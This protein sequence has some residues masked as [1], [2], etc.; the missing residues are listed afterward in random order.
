MDGI[1]SGFTSNGRGTAIL[2]NSSRFEYKKLKLIKDNENGNFITIEIET[3]NISVLINIYGPNNDDPGF[4]RKICADLEKFDTQ[5]Y[6]FFCADWNLIL[7]CSLDVYNYKHINNP[8]ARNYVL[9]MCN[10]L[11]LVDVWRVY[12]ENERKYTWSRRN[13][14]PLMS[15]LDFFLILDDILNFVSDTNI[16]PGYRTD[17]SAITLNL[18]FSP[19]SRGKGYWKFNNSLLHDKN[20]VKLIKESIEEIKEQYAVSPYTRD[21]IKKCPPEELQLQINDQ[22][23][24]EMIL[25]HLRGKLIPYASHK[26]KISREK[27]KKIEEEIMLLEDNKINNPLDFNI[28]DQL[29][30]KQKELEDSRKEKVEGLIIRSRARWYEMGEKSTKYF[31]NLENRNYTNKTIQELTLDSDEIITDQSKILNEIRDFYKNLYAEHNISNKNPREYLKDCSFEILSDAEKESLEGDLSYEELAFVVRNSKN[32]SSP[33]ISGYTNEFYKFFWKDIGYFLL[34]SLNYSYHIGELSINKKRGVITCLPKPGKPRNKIKNWRPIS[35]LNASYKFASACISNRLKKV[36]D[37]LIHDDQKGFISGR[38]IGENT[39]LM[40]DIIYET[41][42]LQIPGLILLIDF[43]KAF[44]T[45]SGSYIGKVLDIF[46]FGSS[47]KNW[48]HTFYLDSQSCVI[49]NGH[50]SSFFKL[51]RGCRQGDPL[52]PYIFLLCAEILGIMMRNNKNIKGIEIFD[53]EFKISHYADDTSVFINGSEKS[54]RESLKVLNIFYELSGLKMNVDKTKVI[55]IGAL[56]GSQVHL[57][58]EYNLGWEEGN[59]TVL[60]IEFNVDLK[61]IIELNFRKKLEEIKRTLTVWKQR[62]LTLLGKITVLKTLIIP[63]LNH[64]FIALPNPEDNI[65]KD[66]EKTFFKFL[67]NKSNDKVKRKVLMQPYNKGGLNMINLI[68]FINSLKISWIRRLITSNSS[69]TTFINAKLKL[70]KIDIFSAGPCIWEHLKKVC[71]P[72]WRDVLEAYTTFV[73]FNLNSLKNEDVLCQPLWFNPKLKFKFIK[74]W[75]DKGIRSINDIVDHNGNILSFENLKITYGIAGTFIEYSALINSIPR[76][77]KNYLTDNIIVKNSYPQQPVWIA[78]LLKFKKGCSHIYKVFQNCLTSSHPMNCIQ[79][80]NEETNVSQ[81]IEIWNKIFTIP[82]KATVETKLREFQY[83]VLHRFLPTRKFLF[84][85]KLIDTDKCTFCGTEVEDLTHLFFNCTHVK[86]LWQELKLWLLSLNET[87]NDLTVT[88]IL[89][90]II[91]G[92]PVINHIIMITKYFIYRSSISNT[93]LNLLKLKENIKMCY[94]IEKQMCL[95]SHS[96]AKFYGK[97]SNFVNVL[98]NPP[99]NDNA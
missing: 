10:S 23:F 11:N 15:R 99:R 65:L 92:Q 54:L 30:K 77:W 59:F 8:N 88:D 13:P 26:K 47:I 18:N 87:V 34:R 53:K 20:C 36:L 67:W 4:Y 22:L 78:Y 31:C 16:I 48:I 63:K 17:H 45:V 86:N 84:K 62:Q 51:G 2:F 46:N 38:F 49:Q 35:L 97:W 55:K 57:C 72:F 68:P 81:D 96:M 83:K 79:K 82:F 91:G 7:S 3:P 93:Q 14:Y 33:G 19:H 41:E 1:I 24:F 52:S 70:V 50:M 28:L 9:E 95:A 56:A 37:K 98:E 6:I 74:N 39:R 90:G 42:K 29:D 60:G 27:E 89:F 73:K 71:N 12:H 61:S 85:I 64:L 66:F 40:Y 69:W 58:P 44:D 80:W 76:N 21:F 75:Y 25:L 94:R 43:E 5:N 32:N